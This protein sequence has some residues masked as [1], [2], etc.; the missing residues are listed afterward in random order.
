[1]QD[2]LRKF[3]LIAALLIGS[4][5]AHAGLHGWTATIESVAPGATGSSYYTIN[6]STHT[7]C[8]QARVFAINVT[9]GSHMIIDPGVCT[10]LVVDIP[11]LIPELARIKWP[12]PPGP[13]CLSC[14]FMFDSLI[15][16]VYP[17]HVDQV[18]S[19]KDKFAIDQYNAELQQL[20]EAYNLQGFEQEMFNIEAEM[21]GKQGR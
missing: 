11:R 2:L 13:V 19:L 12:W 7:N 1:M 18:R 17:Q 4:Q 9:L 14:P 21:A 6:A 20:Q 5:A 10:P 16:V 15:E 8:E 3:V